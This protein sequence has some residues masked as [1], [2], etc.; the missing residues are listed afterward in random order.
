LAQPGPSLNRRVLIKT[1]GAFA[2]TAMVPLLSHCGGDGSDRSLVQR[3]GAGPTAPSRFLSEGEL[4]TL[5]A[6]VDR[7]I[8]GQ[9]EDLDPGAVA[10]CCAEA[11]DYLLAAF[12]TDPP[13]IYAGAPF[14]NRGGSSTNHFLEFVRLDAYEE[15]AWRIAIEGSAGLPARE[16]NG[17]VKGMQQ[18]YREGLAQL[19]QRAREQGFG[20]FAEMPGL[21]RD[22]LIGDSSD[23]TIADMVDIAFPDTLDAMYGPPEYG[24]NCELLGWQFTRYEGDVQPRGYTPAQIVHADNPGLFDALLPPSY[25]GTTAAASAP[26]SGAATSVALTPAVL[27]AMLAGESMAAALMA[28]D[29]SLRRLRVQLQPLARQRLTLLSGGDYRA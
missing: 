29:G 3:P 18:I 1:G 28:A 27:P 2:L 21:F 16:F 7:F 5:R 17:P 12:Q 4:M 10:A 13:F 6:L 15:L 9:P 24:G 26:P 23:A 22:R 20:S 25:D 14:S 8:P 19:E 11:I